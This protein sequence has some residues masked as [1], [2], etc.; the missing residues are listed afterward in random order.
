MKLKG[1]VAIVTGP[2]AGW[3]APSPGA[4]PVKAFKALTAWCQADQ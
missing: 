1:K 4:M 2:A 3:A